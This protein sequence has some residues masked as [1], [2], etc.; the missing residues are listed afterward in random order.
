MGQ[1]AWHVPFSG[2]QWIYLLGG[3]PDSWEGSEVV[4]CSSRETLVAARGRQSYLPYALYYYRARYYSPVFGR[5]ISED[6]LGLSAG[7][8]FL[9]LRTRQPNGVCRSI[10]A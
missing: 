10:W 5:F 4:C 1:R 3:R 9:L 2:R 6:P 7:F 8:E